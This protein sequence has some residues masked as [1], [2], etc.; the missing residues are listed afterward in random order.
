MSL[1]RSSVA[2][3]RI[4]LISF[5]L[6]PELAGGIA[7]VTVDKIRGFEQRGF[8]VTVIGP[9]SRKT[10]RTS[11]SKWPMRSIPVR[12]NPLKFMFSLYWLLIETRL[13]R[14]DFIYSTSATWAGL[15]AS[16][17]GGIYRIPYFVMVHGNE[18]IR[19]EHSPR[20]RT[21]IGLVFRRAAGIMAV[22]RFSA[23]E[24]LRIY[25]VESKKI[26]TVFNGVDHQRFH[27]GEEVAVAEFKRRYAPEDA[28]I[29][30]TLSRIEERKGHS[31]VIRALARLKESKPDLSIRYLIAGKGPFE[32]NLR[33]LVREL[34]LEEQ[35]EF[36]GFIAREDVNLLYSATDLFVMPSVYLKDSGS[37]EGFGLVYVEAGLCGTPSLG[38]TAGGVSDAI[39]D[40]ETGYTVD[41]D[42]IDAIFD[43]LQCLAEDPDT[44]AEMGAKARRYYLEN[45]T[46]DI[47]LDRELTTIISILDQGLSP[48]G[49]RI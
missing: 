10:A 45:L 41:G 47:V 44:V 30:S 27:P 35:V 7:S 21:M 1:R 48:S 6:P 4:I 5:E 40:G 46:L 36:L 11:Y 16:I 34:E 14:P 8:E 20:I 42:N 31:A 3:K 23:A 18:F 28:I 15:A 9:R 26:H 17:A 32:P 29:L 43:I 19:F 49:E 24:V 37:V 39:K 25:G 2:N 33:D 22:S 13:R 12:S 38:G